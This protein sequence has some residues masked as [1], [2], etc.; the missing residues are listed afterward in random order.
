MTNHRLAHDT[1]IQVAGFDST[2]AS[3]RFIFY[4]FFCLGFVLFSFAH[5]LIRTYVACK[6]Y[7]SNANC[8]GPKSQWANEN[9]H[10]ISF[11]TNT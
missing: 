11:E 7:I 6:Y 3:M 2:I 5:T 10:N 1:S 8:G 9:E 4:A